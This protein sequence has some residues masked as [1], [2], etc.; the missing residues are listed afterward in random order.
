MGAG[1]DEDGRRGDNVMV[2]PLPRFDDPP[3]TPGEGL[4]NKLASDLQTLLP[5][6]LLPW[7]ELKSRR[8]VRDLKWIGL[9]LLGSFPMIAFALGGAN[10]PVIFWGF[11]LYFAAVWAVFFYF[12]FQ[13][14]EG[15]WK[16]ALICFFFSGVI[17]LLAFFPIL[18]MGAESWR[19]VLIFSPNILVKF[20]G[21]LVTVAIPQYLIGMAPILFFLR[22]GGPTPSLPTM[23]FCGLISG[24]SWGMA[25]AINWQLDH[26]V[27]D[28]SVPTFY[29]QSILQL[30]MAPFMLAVWTGLGAFFLTLARLHP[31]RKY[32]LWLIAVCLP[33]LLQ[34]IHTAA[35]VT[36]ITV[37]VDLFA[38]FLFLTYFFRRTEIES[39]LGIK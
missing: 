22:P 5:Q 20:F 30:T 8:W 34:S 31:S 10:L 33:L 29:L 15:A 17:A 39:A 9:L 13:P 36:W 26:S 11:A 35:S 32:G 28:Q 19:D 21:E 18:Q 4:P 27:R 14:G 24:L 7:E 2:T 6:L 1:V 23:V 12:F 38:T 25:E 16:P 37:V 3:P